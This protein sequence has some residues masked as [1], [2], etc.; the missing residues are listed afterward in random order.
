MINDNTDSRTHCPYHYQLI[1]LLSLS[2]K[3]QKISW[4]LH[5][6]RWNVMRMSVSVAS[7]SGFSVITFWSDKGK[8]W[9]KWADISWFSES[10]NLNLL[11]VVFSWCQKWRC[12]KTSHLPPISQIFKPFPHWTFVTLPFPFP[13]II[14]IET[15][16]N[17][18]DGSFPS[19]FRRC[20]F[21]AS[22]PSLLP[23]LHSFLINSMS[24]SSSDRRL[25]RVQKC[26]ASLS[27]VI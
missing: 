27:T 3:F 19:S 20:R 13:I 10:C 12:L 11:G 23:H 25:L 21:S 24:S 15:N 6:N 7:L 9:L 8:D 14:I 1:S 17:V 26:F 4:K 5:G 18:G 22:R 2:K 16:Q